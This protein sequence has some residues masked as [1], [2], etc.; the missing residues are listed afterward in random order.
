MRDGVLKVKKDELEELP[1]GEFYYYEIIG[2]DVYDQQGHEIGKVKEILSPGANDVWVVQ[3]KEDKKEF[4]IPYI[5]QV[6]KEVT[7]E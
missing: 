5:E 2:C 1:E 7:R 4:L 6:V 3:S